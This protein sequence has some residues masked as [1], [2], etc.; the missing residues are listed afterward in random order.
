MVFQLSFNLTTTTERPSYLLPYTAFECSPFN[1]I[2]LNLIRRNSIHFTLWDFF[3][4]TMQQGF[5]GSSVSLGNELFCFL[6]EIRITPFFPFSPYF[7]QCGLIF[8]NRHA[9]DNACIKEESSRLRNFYSIKI[10]QWFALIIRSGGWNMNRNYFDFP[11][12]LNESAD[13]TS[14]KALLCIC[15]FSTAFVCTLKIE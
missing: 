9:L 3:W 7:F 6:V 1:F 4:L 11:A 14:D 8:Q 12:S 5:F 10:K 13:T 15:T 2:Q